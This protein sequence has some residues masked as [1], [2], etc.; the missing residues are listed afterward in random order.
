MKFFLFLIISILLA[1]TSD[2][3]SKLFAP[4]IVSKGSQFGMA[5]APNG[6]TVF[7]VQSYGGRDTLRIYQSQRIKR[8]WQK[9]YLAFF[10]DTQFKQID[11]T[12]SP[13]GKTILFNSLANPEKGFDIY[14]VYQND[15]GWGVPMLLPET[16]NSNRSDFYATMS[17]NGNIYFTRR[18]ASND[19]Y[20][21]KKTVTGYSIA[22]PL[23][24]PI[25]TLKNESNPYISPDES[26][27]IFFADLSDSYGDVDLYISFNKD[28]KWSVPQNL[29]SKVNTGAGE[30]CP[31]VDVRG[32]QFLFSRTEEKN[33]KLKENM[34]SIPLKELSLDALKN[35]AIFY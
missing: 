31:S 5:M 30:F 18:M 20:V 28:G 1:K 6:N 15:T 25:N 26:Y 10:A 14:A 24:S 27:L 29:G 16:V 7:Y 22:I 33:G 17:S 8:K 34:H 32:K 2:A 19:I 21:S 13:D 35:T 9:P 11:P 3:Q 4:G 12:I 23:D